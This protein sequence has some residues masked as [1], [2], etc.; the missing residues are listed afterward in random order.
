MKTPLLTIMIAAMTLLPR[1]SLADPAAL[2][3]QNCQQCHGVDRMGG[4]GLTLLPESPDRLKPAEVADTI[5]HGR[6]ATQMQGFA[7]KL[8]ESDILSLALLSEYTTCPAAA[9]AGGGHARQPQAG[10]GRSALAC[11]AG[12]F[13]QPH[14]PFCGGGSRRS[15]CHHHGWRYF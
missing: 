9:L 2:Y 7:G 10:G 8:A 14:E 15:S 13:G 11:Q 4:M 1:L 5:R 6:R 3:Q 12:V